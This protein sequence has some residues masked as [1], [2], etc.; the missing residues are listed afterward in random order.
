MNLFLGAI[1]ALRLTKLQSGGPLEWLGDPTSND[2]DARS[3]GGLPIPGSA[4][5][6]LHRLRD[7]Q[8]SI[9]QKPVTAR[10][11]ALELPMPTRK[12]KTWRGV[13]RRQRV[14]QADGC[15]PRAQ[16][17]AA[18]AQR[19]GTKGGTHRL[20]MVEAVNGTNWTRQAHKLPNVR[21]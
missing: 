1:A 16:A 21:F 6:D 12:T 13:S 10:K 9:I 3:E 18:G 4:L 15:S 7:V 11:S 19:H 14:G 2:N 5:P 8:I 17:I 20:A